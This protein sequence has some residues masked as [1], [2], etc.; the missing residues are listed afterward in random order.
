LNNVNWFHNNRYQ[1]HVSGKKRKTKK[2]KQ[3]KTKKT[4]QKKQNN[5][6]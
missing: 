6:N 4:K 3:K 5:L 1:R 2:S